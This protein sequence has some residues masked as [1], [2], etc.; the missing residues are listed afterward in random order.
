MMELNGDRH[1]QLHWGDHRYVV[2]LALSQGRILG[3]GAYQI[4]AAPKKAW[5]DNFNV[6]LGM[7]YRFVIPAAQRRGIATRLERQARLQAARFLCEKDRVSH[8]SEARPLLLNEASNPPRMPVPAYRE[9]DAAG[10]NPCLRII[11]VWGKAGFHRIW[12]R[13]GD[14]SYIEPASSDGP[15][16]DYYNL[17]AKTPGR[18]PVQASTV[19]AIVTWF[20]AIRRLYGED[21]HGH[22]RPFAAMTDQMKGYGLLRPMDDA[23]F[24]RL[25]KPRIDHVLRETPP[26]HPDSAQR[27]GDLL[28][29]KFGHG[30]RWYAHALLARETPPTPFGIL[31]DVH[32]RLRGAHRAGL[33]LRYAGG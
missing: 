15:Q 6:A 28:K 17:N 2:T 11:D 12:P 5:G 18:M 9:D 30:L 33:E 7:D 22:S 21:P 31:G 16:C 25:L 23:S 13:R 20:A 19:A 10:I 14:Q 4:M 24:L 3:A 27:V 1:M 32:S 29:Q 8:P 26:D